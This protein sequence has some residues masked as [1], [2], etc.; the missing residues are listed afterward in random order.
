ILKVLRVQPILGHG[1]RRETETPPAGAMGQFLI[2]YGLWQR[3][4]GG[5]SDIVGR[6]VLLEG[7][8]PREVIGVLPRGFDFRD[9]TEAWTSVPLR[10]VAERDR[11]EQSYEVVARLAPGATVA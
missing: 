7:R 4:F 10:N 6:R 5:A 8:L 11:R 1:F 2:S 3:A 9:G